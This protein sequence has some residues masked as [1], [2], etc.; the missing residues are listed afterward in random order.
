[1]VNCVRW[2][3]GSDESSTNYPGKIPDGL[4]LPSDVADEKLSENG[5]TN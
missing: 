1:M 4:D 5:P 3:I 2:M